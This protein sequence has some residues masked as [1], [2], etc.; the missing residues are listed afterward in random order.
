M[1][2]SDW[3]LYVYCYSMLYSQVRGSCD[4]WVRSWVCRLNVPDTLMFDI[5]HI[6]IE[7]LD[8]ES[9]LFGDH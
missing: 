9:L 5:M 2:M 7:I 6:F 3:S 1:S 4:S 8:L